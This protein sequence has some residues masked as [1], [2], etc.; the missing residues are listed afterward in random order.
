MN[1]I[2]KARRSENTKKTLGLQHQSH[3]ER[4]GSAYLVFVFV[5]LSLFRAFVTQFPATGTRGPYQ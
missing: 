2:T 4:H 5:V 3:V 1:S